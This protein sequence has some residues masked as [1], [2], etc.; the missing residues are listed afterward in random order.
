MNFN[1]ETFEILKTTPIF[2]F[3]HLNT[4]QFHIHNSME[5]N[6]KEIEVLKT[7]IIKIN[8]LGMAFEKNLFKESQSFQV[9]MKNHVKDDKIAQYYQLIINN[10]LRYADGIQVKFKKL[11]DQ[12]RTLQT[13]EHNFRN[14]VQ[15]VKKSLN[16]SIVK[17]DEKLNLYLKSYESFMYAHK[18]YDSELN[19]EISCEVLDEKE[20][21]NLNAHEELKKALSF[22]SDNLWKKLKETS[23]MEKEIKS[24]IT[25]SSLNIIKILS[26]DKEEDIDNKIKNLDAN[27]EHFRLNFEDLARDMDINITKQIRI[28]DY[29]F[30]YLSANDFYKLNRILDNPYSKLI[31]NKIKEKQR[32]LNTRA[33]ICIELLCEKLYTTKEEFNERT[34]TEIRSILS[35]KHYTDYFIHNLIHKK[36]VVLL[37]S[38]FENLVLTKT[39]SKNFLQIAQ[40]YF[41]L[42]VEDD[43][44]N[45]ETI[46]QFLKFCLTCFNDNNKCLLE[47]LNKTVLLQDCEFWHSLMMFFTTYPEFQRTTGD[48]IANVNNNVSMI[49]GLKSLIA[50]FTQS[51]G[52]V[53]IHQLK[54]AFEEITFLI[55]KC[56]LNFESINDILM[57]LAPKANISFDSVRSLLE[58]NKDSFLARI[59]KE[60]IM[61]TKIKVDI[62]KYT[63]SGDEGRY[64]VMINLL[65]P[66]F[67]NP[68]S[69]LNLLLLNKFVYSKRINVF[70]TVLSLVKIKNE[71]FRKEIIRHY[72]INTKKIEKPDMTIPDKD[73]Q[74]IIKLDIRRTFSE[75]KKFNS[76]TLQLILVNITHAEKGGFHYYQG[77]NYV[78]CYFFLVF[79]ENEVDTYNV[80]M[81]F[82]NKFLVDYTDKDFNNL[83]K[84]F[85][86]GKRLMKIYLPQ[87]SNYLENEQ[88]VDIDIILASWC[89]TIFTTVMQSN[90]NTTLMDQLMEIFISKGWPGF[91]QII[92]VIFDELQKT[93]LKLKF[94]EIILL[95][96]DI[97][98]SNFK[99]VVSNHQKRYGKKKEFNFKDK[100]KKF[101][102]VNKAQIHYL[103]EEHEKILGKINDFWLR[104]SQKFKENEKNKK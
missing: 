66:F 104:I 53:T 84:L 41:L 68:K 62:E 63:K 50:S 13:S 75:K 23:K 15:N 46:Y 65:L 100:I 28:D 6:V 78:V 21:G 85:F 45:N 12:I 93:I 19:L 79:K 81:A 82:I 5:S 9:E 83:K 69:I 59:T 37:I 18:G 30:R 76:N 42:C 61:R 80:S 31:F 22:N 58:K 32:K 47:L 64:I 8:K 97:C 99:E 1:N 34:I 4:A 101:K 60:D 90:K 16:S 103:K 52:N 73:I 49:F 44:Q 27:L 51:Q 54:K 7:F 102:H 14:V 29:K 91:F 2:L 39:Q 67:D 26:P 77:L 88:K 95:L 87:L 70:R 72:L 92:L 17:L 33:K 38:P 25:E 94:E 86:Y 71:D 20:K 48:E 96:S 74:N 55:F 35:N 89:L 40:Y 10:L 3:N 56:K 57:F 11:L 43:K 24:K 98:K 36:I